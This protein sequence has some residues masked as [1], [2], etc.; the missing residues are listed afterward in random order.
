MFNKN[1]LNLPILKNDFFQFAY[2]IKNSIIV[3]TYKKIQPFG[4]HFKFI[5]EMFPKF[6]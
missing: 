6:Q 5:H 4:I 1:Y 2:F 3:F